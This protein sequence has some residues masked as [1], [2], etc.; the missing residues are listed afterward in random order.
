MA[1]ERE[2]KD[3]EQVKDLEDLEVAE[4]DDESLEDVSG[5][6]DKNCGCGPSLADDGS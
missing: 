4:L 3:E 1:Q 5:G 2:K 6:G